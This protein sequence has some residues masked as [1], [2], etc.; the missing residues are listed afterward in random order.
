MHTSAGP[1]DVN[2]CGVQDTRHDTRSSTS[3][4]TILPFDLTRIGDTQEQIR[5]DKVAQEAQH[6]DP[7][8]EKDVEIG[9]KN[10][11]GV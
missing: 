11:E 3:Q 1:C 7:G 6:L 10:G 9:E 5:S 2:E 4:L 8:M